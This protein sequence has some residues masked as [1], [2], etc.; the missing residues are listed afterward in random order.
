ME[1]RLNVQADKRDERD[2]RPAEAAAD[3]GPPTPGPSG[4]PGAAMRRH[5]SFLLAPVICLMTLALVVGLARA[6][7]YTANTRLAVGG[8]SSTS[9]TELMGFA[10][11]AQQLAQTYSRSVQGDAVVAEVARRMHSSREQ[12]SSRLSAAPIPETPVFTL[13]A[14]AGSSEGAVRL[15]NLA[16]QAL[17]SEVSRASQADPPRLLEQYQAAELERGQISK[18]ID[19]LT[20]THG[21]GLAAAQSELLAVEARADSLRT[22][23]AA[24][25]QN[26]TVPLQIIERA[27]SA[28][29]DRLS[30]L[31]LY[32]F[33]ALILGLVIGA[34]LALFR[35]TPAY[36]RVIRALGTL[37][38]RLSSQRDRA[39]G[40]RPGPA[41]GSNGRPRAVRG[42]S[43]R[44][45]A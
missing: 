14:T 1:T 3:G 44:R 7:T 13:S 34:A 31:Q 27:D 25:Q 22:A 30:V 28:G 33:V 36:D 41:G 16:G 26:A 5:P 19:E 9:P 21:P 4:S 39:T 6:P 23:Y 8:L 24:G 42:P 37:P 40:A 29:S 32:L 20:A 35:D 11:A 17:V 15:S 18:R 2:G 45:R 43:R 38:N 12:V 10:D